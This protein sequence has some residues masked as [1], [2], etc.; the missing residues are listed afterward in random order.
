MHAE[1]ESVLGKAKEEDGEALT[2]LMVC[3]MPRMADSSSSTCFFSS[4]TTAKLVVCTQRSATAKDK[5][6]HQGT[7]Q[8]R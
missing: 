1:T 4:V 8:A 2:L 6:G 7:T 5:E 3:F